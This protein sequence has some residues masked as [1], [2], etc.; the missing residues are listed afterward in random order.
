MCAKHCDKFYGI[1]LSILYIIT[2]NL[3]ILYGNR[4]SFKQLWVLLICSLLIDLQMLVQCLT[5]YHAVFLSTQDGQV[6]RST[7]NLL[8]GNVLDIQDPGC[9]AYG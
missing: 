1:F 2:M 3:V 8:P 9:I 6:N 4:G 7:D 5:P